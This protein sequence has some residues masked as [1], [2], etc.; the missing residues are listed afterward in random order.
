MASVADLIAKAEL[1]CE[2]APILLERGDIDGA[3]NRA[4][5]AMFGAGRAAPL[6]TGS[7]QAATRTHV[8]LFSAFGLRLVKS[9]KVDRTLGHALNRAQEIRLVADHAGDLVDREAAA[10]VVGRSREFVAA[11]RD[12]VAATP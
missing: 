4:Y 9:G 7:D 1:A 10:W 6:A 5:Y 11:M 8:D 12:F 2:P 3:C